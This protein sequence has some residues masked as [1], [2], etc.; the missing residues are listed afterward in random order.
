MSAFVVNN[1][2]IDLLVTAALRYGITTYRTD[3]TTG[4]LTVERARAQDPT[5]LGRRLIEANI[6]S[7]WTRYGDSI[8]LPEQA[9]YVA[10]ALSYTH[11]PVLWEGGASVDFHFQVIMTS[12]CVSYQCCEIDTWAASMAHAFV[13]AVREAAVR[14]LDGYRDAHW[15][16]RRGLEI[17]TSA[18]EGQRIFGR[19]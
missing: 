4:E 9:D 2:A 7:V 19:A 11:D 12:H 1:D 18:E 6:I 8:D 17:R 3:P 10:Q 5:T 13:T 15:T 14:S 16:W